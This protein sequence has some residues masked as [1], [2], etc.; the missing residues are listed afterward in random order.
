[1]I[2]ISN[3]GSPLILGMLS[4]LLFIFLV[5]KKRWCHSLL[6]F[7]SM[8]GGWISGYLLKASI[9]RVR[10]DDAL[11]MIPNGYSFP[12][13]HA[14]MAIIFF[15]L[16]IHIFQNEIQDRIARMCF[17]A[18]NIFAFL[19]IGF[20]RIYLSV[21]WMSDVLAGFGLGMFWLTFLMLALKISNS[22][23]RKRRKYTQ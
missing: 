16:L 11:I 2:F 23:L 18:V 9:E 3:A 15:S 19:L 8:T 20:S 5:Y 10:P 14:T 13:A 21:H 17:V 6:V 4:F 1:M 22:F 12:S 7:L